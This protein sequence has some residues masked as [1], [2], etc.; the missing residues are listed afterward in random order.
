MEMELIFERLK[1]LQDVLAEKVELEKSLQEVPKLLTDQ[2]ELLERMKK[3]FLEKHQEYEKAR[4]AASDFRALLAEAEGAREKAE[5]NMDAISTQREYEILDR[6]IKEAG[7]KAQQYRK[8]MLREEKLTAELDEEAKG[9][10]ALVKQ[11]EAELME[12]R[13]GID[14][15]ITKKTAQISKLTAKEEEL[16]A[17]LDPELVFKFTRIIR[18][19]GKGMED[20]KG[21]VCS[22]CHMILPTQFANDVRAGRE[23]VFCPYCSMILQYREPEDED[24][25]FD[26]EDAGS[27][28]DLDDLEEDGGEDEE[29]DA[30]MGMEEESIGTGFD[31]V[32][33]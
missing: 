15:D 28:A 24:A 31:D 4:S 5:K 29:G 21:A 9:I 18:K 32:D 11:Q 1:G 7:D 17:G 12:R 14:K 10:A 22:G 26:N 19:H 27:L 8:D 3:N 30:G 13:K 2:E 25:L 20:L 6:E 33:A 16:T 23:I